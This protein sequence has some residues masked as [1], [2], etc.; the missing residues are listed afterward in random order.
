MSAKLLLRPFWLPPW[1]ELTKCA[2]FR[3][4]MRLRLRVAGAERSRASGTSAFPSWSLGTRGISVFK[5]LV[6]KLQRSSL[7][8]RGALLYAPPAPKVLNKTAQGKRV[9]PVRPGPSTALGGRPQ[10]AH[11]PTGQNRRLVVPRWGECALGIGPRAAL[12]ILACPGL[13]CEGPLAQFSMNSQ[14]SESAPDC[15]TPLT[16]CK[17]RETFPRSSLPPS[18]PAG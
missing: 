11:A 12:V 2:R 6:P 15:A 16:A 5:I 10:W 13:S 18:H 17:Y 14:T 7:G 4:R 3:S 1:I 9:L 8:T